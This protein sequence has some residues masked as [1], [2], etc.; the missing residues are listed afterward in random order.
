MHAIIFFDGVCNLCNG[1][2]QFVIARDLKDHFR[3]A[4]L[5]SEFAKHKLSMFG[6]DPEKEDSILVLEHNKVY[7][8]SAAVLRITRK[9]GG[10]WPLLYAGIIF[11]PFVRNAIY[12]W[13][14]KN[15]Y[16]WFGKQESCWIPTPELKE[17]FLG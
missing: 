11:P 9:L 12:R 13:I 1:A 16:R 10:L 8:Q 15:R 14:A 6:I 7:R 17:K 5:Q 4:S 3:Y 2:V